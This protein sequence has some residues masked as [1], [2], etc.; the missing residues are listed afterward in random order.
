MLLDK[1][2]LY[3]E[4]GE[5]S[6]AKP[7]RIMRVHLLPEPLVVALTLAVLEFAAAVLSESAFSFLGFGVKPP[8][9]RRGV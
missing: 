5:L 2:S 4:A 3:V 7:S 9:T 1:S 6:G 8:G